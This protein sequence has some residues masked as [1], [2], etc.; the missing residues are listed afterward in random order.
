M[1]LTYSSYLKLEELLAL[2]KPQSQG[3]AHDEML[4]IIIHQTY[5]L[6]FKETLHEIDF[7]RNCL[8]CCNPGPAQATLKRLL[9]ILKVMVAQFDILETMTSPQFLAFRDLLGTA[10]GFQS[11]Q[12][13]E[14]EFVM[15]NKRRQILEGL[16]EGSPSRQRLEKRYTET[17]LWDA[18][19]HFLS[20]CGYGIPAHVLNRDLKRPI[21]SS[22]QVQSVLLQ[23]YEKSP[24]TA[25]L[26]E[27][28][29]DLDEGLQE[30]RY[31]HVKMVERIIGSKP[32]TGGSDGVEYLKSTL[33]IPSFPDLWAIRAE[34]KKP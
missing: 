8:E 19:M 1:A 10:S 24:E 28:L 16:P 18:F 15:G 25:N 11:L 2:Q 6:W 4:F 33:F 22:R 7:I 23:I 13:R 26:C 32:G 20:Q 31:R 3:K 14:L 34:F 29:F 12:F 30:W 9:S 27:L 5:E 17:T 21:T